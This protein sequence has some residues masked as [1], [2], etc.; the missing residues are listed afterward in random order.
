LLIPPVRATF[1]AAMRRLFL[2]LSCGLTTHAVADDFRSA[3]IKA[4]AQRERQFKTI[5][6]TWKT[7]T[8]MPKGGRMDVDPAG[9]PLP[10]ED[11]T[12]ESTHRLVLDGDRLRAEHDDSGLRRGLRSEVDGI[13]A[14]DGERTHQ[15]VY[16][17]GRDQPA[18]LMRDRDT[19][20]AQLGGVTVRPL[21]MWC[22]GARF[23]PYRESGW[24]RVQV[25]QS[26]LEGEQQIR[27]RLNGP[28]GSTI[29]LFLD[30]RR[31]YLVRRVREESSAS[32]EVTDIA[33][34]QQPEIGWVPERWT[35]TQTRDGER[36]VQWSRAEVTDIRCNEPVAPATFRLDPLPGEQ[37]TDTNLNKFYR[38]GPNGELEEFDPLTGQPALIET[39]GRSISTWPGRNLVR[40]VM[41]P[42]LLVVIL[43]LVILRR[44]SRSPHTPSS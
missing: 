23:G 32:V 33:Y 34:R 7:T 35:W 13:F 17:N 30:P 31:D 19:S 15:R 28:A 39:E 41:L 21:A 40:Y 44:R 24:D 8:F 42:A 2:L 14:A 18:I 36:L 9:L 26:D 27:L 11:I 37:V 1:L 6:V 38:A 5:S 12:V 25:S 20:L 4:S 3:A 16:Q 29:T 43:A 10:R 22:R